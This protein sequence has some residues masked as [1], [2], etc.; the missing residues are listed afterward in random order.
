VQN[1]NRAVMYSVICFGFRRI[2]GYSKES[3]RVLKD[4]KEHLL[5]PLVCTLTEQLDSE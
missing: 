3:L 5:C 4:G 2:L 1:D